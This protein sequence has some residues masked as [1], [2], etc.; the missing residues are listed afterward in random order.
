MW[1]IIA[2]VIVT[3]ILLMIS[4]A[5]LLKPRSHGFYRFFAWEAISALIILNLPVWFD[6]PLAWYQIISWI[7]LIVCI[8]PLALGVN[9][10]QERGAP[11]PHKRPEPQLLSF[12]K[13]TKLVTSGVYNYI[14]HPLYSSL[15]LLGWGV[16]F[17][18]PSQLGFDLTITA[19]AFLYATAKTDEAECIQTFGADYQDYM[20][21]T[22]MFIPYVF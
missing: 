10:L 3:V 1:Q 17:K 18:N 16:F 2:F 9:A 7:L 19:T 12:E 4:R 13:T 6:N 15:F 14:R 11:D 5:S 21:R 20:R 8:L 22:T